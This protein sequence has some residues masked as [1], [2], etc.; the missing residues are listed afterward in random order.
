[1]GEEWQMVQ[2]K[3]QAIRDNEQRYSQMD[4]YIIVNNNPTSLGHVID[5][6]ARKRFL[7]EHPL[8]QLSSVG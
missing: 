8:P 1:M 3:G 7:T 5:M 2:W 4:S 6:L